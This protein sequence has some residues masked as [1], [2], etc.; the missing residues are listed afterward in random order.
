MLMG[1]TGDRD[2]GGKGRDHD[3]DQRDCRGKY[4][5]S[6]SLKKAYDPQGSSPWQTS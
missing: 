3:L 1:E 2:D 4:N 6:Y 5:T